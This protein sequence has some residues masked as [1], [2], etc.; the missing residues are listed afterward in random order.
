MPVVSVVIPT[1]N[2]ALT[3]V[4]AVESALN[5]THSETQVIVIDDGSTDDTARRLVPYL[6]KIQ[7]L[8]QEN[9]GR[10]AARNRG[11]RAA[12]GR[13]VAFLDSDDWWL[14]RKVE[15]LA[16]VLDAN[17]RVG[18]VYSSCFLVQATGAQAPQRYAATQ[19]DHGS[20]VFEEL[21]MRNF[22]GSPSN[23]MIRSDVVQAVGGFDETL[24]AY[25]DWDL[26]LRI[27]ADYP[28]AYVAQPLTLY[29]LHAGRQFDHMVTWNAAN[30]WFR[31][32]DRLFEQP[33]IRSRYGYLENHARARV[34][35]RSA[36]IDSVLRKSEASRGKLKHA[37]D[38]Y[39]P[40]FASPFGELTQL[41]LD[42]ANATIQTDSQLAG[43]FQAI[44]LFWRDLRSV[45]RRPLWKH[46]R[47]S[48]GMLCAQH[49]FESKD[50][51]DWATIR[52]VGTWAAWYDVHWLRNQGFVLTWLRSLVGVRAWSLAR[53]LLT[54]ARRLQKPQR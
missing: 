17:P 2:S 52:R 46:R 39:P 11:I 45:V 40:F 32:V 53:G 35:V 42:C 4:A 41:V 19:D 30:D 44:D 9:V 27:A 24:H 51:E 25:E 49:L 21:A 47:K 10:S 23:V 28:V 48:K 13:Y 3:V 37:A 43:G 8:V 5:Q 34:L 18:L 7:Y 50:R 38:L 54:R 20:Y 31:I 14:P 22:I 1:Y 15:I 33:T 26:Y 6:E 36:L 16:A 29:R 12:N